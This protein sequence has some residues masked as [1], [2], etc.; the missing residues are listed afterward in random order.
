MDSNIKQKLFSRSSIFF[1]FKKY[2][3]LTST[4]NM[5]KTDVFKVIKI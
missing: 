2:C 4:L 5:V 3:L 1:L